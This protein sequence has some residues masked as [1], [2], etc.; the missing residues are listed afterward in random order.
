MHSRR[1]RR[2]SSQTVASSPRRRCRA[3]PRA[4][5]TTARART[6]SWASRATP[7][8]TRFVAR[9]VDKPCGGIPTRIRT[10]AT[11][12]SA[13]RARTRRCETKS[14]A[15]GTIARVDSDTRRD[16]RDEGARKT[17]KP[18][19]TGTRRGE[20]NAETKGGR[21]RMRMISMDEDTFLTRSR[22][23]GE[24]SGTM[25]TGRAVGEGWGRLDRSD[26]IRSRWSAPIRF[27]DG[28]G[29]F[30]KTSIRWTDGSAMG[31]AET[32]EGVGWEARFHRRRR[33]E[34]EG[35]R[36]QRRLRRRRRLAPMAFDERAR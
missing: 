10:A 34:D 35:R 2:E 16:A 36:G 32:V 21:R 5:T 13:R 24:C 33:S 1:A 27:F 28:D 19:R 4:R 7:R 18:T 12:S 6:T 9:I 22:R 15:R 20:A 29:R 23:S 14:D 11:R 8:S 17:R 3:R 31:S 26:G 25:R 30:L